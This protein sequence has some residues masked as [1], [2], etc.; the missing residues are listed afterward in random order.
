MR[1]PALA[2]IALVLCAAGP[3]PATEDV[4]WVRAAMIY[5]GMDVND[6]IIELPALMEAAESFV[7]KPV[8]KGHDWRDPDAC[9][10]VITAVGVRENKKV[11]NY[12]LQA[13]FEIRDAQAISKIRRGL[14]RL[15]SIGFMVTGEEC[16]VDRVSMLRCGHRRGMWRFDENGKLIIYQMII[17]EFRGLECSFINVPACSEAMVQ[18]FS[19]DP[20]RL[21]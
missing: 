19:G 4:L 16:S 17:T 8:L 6:S 5:E 9:I 14:Y 15:L 7:G 1:F 11:G 10:G 21:Q 20:L 18:D 2:M 3:A 13:I 12:Y